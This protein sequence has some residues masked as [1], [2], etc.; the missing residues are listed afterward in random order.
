ELR[1]RVVDMGPNFANPGLEPVVPPAHFPNLLVNGAAGIA[2]GMA[3]SIPPHNLGECVRACVYLIDNPDASTA[4]LLDRI[5]G[6]DFPLGG[7]VLTDRTA[8]RKIYED[9]T[10]T[11]KIQAEW[12]LEEAGRKPQIIV[13]SIP[14]GVDKGKLENAIG[15]IIASR[16]L[17]QLLGLTNE[18]N[19]KEGLRIALEIKADTD[20][21]LVMAYLN[22][23]TQLQETFSYNLTCLVPTEDGATRPEKLGLKEMLR[24]FLDFRFA[25]VR[26]RFEY[27]LEQLR[28]RI[29]ILQGFKI[30]FNALDK[31]IKFI[32]ESDGK[33]DAAQ[34]LMKAFKLDEIQTEAVLDAQLYRIAQLEIK[35]ILD[36]L[37]EKK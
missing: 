15:A 31:A 5:K 9:G 18:S 27:D 12:K 33:P 24:H 2:V 26:R 17:P 16:S 37:K 10:G 6:P 28:K 36:E 19:E 20:P 25:T 11:I 14:Y 30:V 22:K 34:K 29:H 7:K 1:Q 35:K 32:R 23:H 8:L 21:N 4:Q 13:T 3:T